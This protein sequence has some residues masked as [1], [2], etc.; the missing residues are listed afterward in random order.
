[1]GN[2]DNASHEPFQA[3]ER[4]AFQGQCFAILKAT[5]P[6]GQVTLTA[7]APSLTGSAITIEAVAP[8]VEK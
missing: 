7:S 1:V 6:S 4:H 3:S 5:A 8:S 2:G